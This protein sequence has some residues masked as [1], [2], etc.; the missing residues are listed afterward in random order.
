[1][2]VC[3]DLTQEDSFHAFL[4]FHALKIGII[5]HRFGRFTLRFLRIEQV[6]ESRSRD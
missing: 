1:M 5:F 3:A 4:L 6:L 2:K